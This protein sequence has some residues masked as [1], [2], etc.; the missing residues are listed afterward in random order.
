MQ[1]E[2]A[3]SST[4]AEYIGL[5]RA[6]RETIP[7]MRLLKEMQQRGFPIPCHSPKVHCRVFEDNS[8]AVEMATVHKMRPRT[9][10]LNIKYHFRQHVDSGEVMIHA[11][12]SM[13]NF[14][15]MLTKAQ[16]FALLCKHRNAILGWDV[17]CEKGCANTSNLEG[18]D[19]LNPNPSQSQVQRAQANT[20]LLR[21]SREGANVQH[22]CASDVRPKK[23]T[24][25]TT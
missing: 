8:G 23:R 10:H 3:L 9:K 1:T 6:L 19:D 13:D 24:R 4:K 14:S 22:D 2:I 11:I 5:S 12:R 18:T 16:P 15:D 21:S 17:D 25:C 20:R 7:L